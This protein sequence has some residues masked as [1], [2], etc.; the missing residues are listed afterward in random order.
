VI[1][2]N[3]PEPEP[4]QRTCCR[5]HRPCAT[6]DGKLIHV[7]DAE[8]D[9]PT[10]RTILGDEIEAFSLWIYTCRWCRGW[11]TRRRN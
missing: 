6:R 10:C 8:Y 1:D 4:Q 9:K 5:C 2:R 11:E 3:L 7:P